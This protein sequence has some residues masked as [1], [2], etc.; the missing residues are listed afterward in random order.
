LLVPQGLAQQRRV[1][2]PAGCDAIS[3]AAFMQVG[4]SGSPPRRASTPV[5]HA[6]P[7]HCRHESASFLARGAKLRTELEAVVRDALK[8]VPGNHLGIGLEGNGQVRLVGPLIELPEEREIEAVKA[9][10]DQAG[11]HI[12]IA[13][14]RSASGSRPRA[15]ERLSGVRHHSP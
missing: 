15:D 12:A 11:G 7:L 8:E 13:D 3:R 6:G 14:D 10:H 1:K 5:R 9:L 2:Q 4:H